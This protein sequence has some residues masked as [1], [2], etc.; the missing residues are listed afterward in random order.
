MNPI[1]FRY[2]AFALHYSHVIFLGAF[3][4]SYQ[5]SYVRARKLGIVDGDWER[6]LTYYLIG[7]F[8]G[9]RAGYILEH[10]PLFRGRWLEMLTLWHGAFSLWGAILGFLL[11]SVILRLRHR[12]QVLKGLDILAFAFPLFLSIAVWGL[13]TEGEGWGKVGQ[14]FWTIEHGGV[15]RYPLWLGY[16]LWYFLTAARLIG[17][18]SR[19]E[20]ENFLYMSASLALAAL[21]FAP[22][23]VQSSSETALQYTWSIMLLLASLWLL[24]RREAKKALK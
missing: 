10:F 20:G 6:A 3:L 15:L 12:P 1:L 5:L 9:G 17:R 24:F 23:T 8:L 7:G 2:G 4:L 19:W 16:S 21:L 11:A 18:Q 22:W 14:S 13:F